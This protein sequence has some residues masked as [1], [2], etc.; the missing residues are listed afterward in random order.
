MVICGSPD[1]VIEQCKRYMDTGMDTLLTMHQVG[2]IPHET[3]MRS[4]QLFGE[5]VI[6]A[7]KKESAAREAAQ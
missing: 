6:P 3:V 7:I 2:A 4:I 1:T 5:H